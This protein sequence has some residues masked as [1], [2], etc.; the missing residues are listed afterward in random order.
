[1]Q[2]GCFRGFHQVVDIRSLERKG[3]LHRHS[4]NS[5]QVTILGIIGRSPD[6]KKYLGYPLN[7][8]NLQEMVGAAVI[9]CIA[10]GYRQRVLQKV[11]K[12]VVD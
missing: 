4:R 7:P 6:R 8:A 2:L 10:V 12:G 1:M 9:H 5:A 3:G 11:L